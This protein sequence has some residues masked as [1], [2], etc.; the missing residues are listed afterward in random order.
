MH[1]ILLKRA[2]RDVRGNLFRYLALLLLIA[3]SLY[4]VVGTVAAAESTIASVDEAARANNLEDGQ[5]G[6]F[7]PL[8]ADELAGLAELGIQVEPAFYLDY[9]QPDGSTL[10]LMKNREN[11]NKVEVEQGRAVRAGDEAVVERLYAQATTDR[12]SVV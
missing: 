2:F 11:V 3:A 6:T 5:F 10:R 1:R 8:T 9:A 12:K 7:A 4:L